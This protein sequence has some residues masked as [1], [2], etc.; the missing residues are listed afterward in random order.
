MKKAI[1]LIICILLASNLLFPQESNDKEER[2]I[3]KQEKKAQK[4]AKKAEKI[5]QG[6]FLISPLAAPGYTPELGGLF[7]IG[8]LTSFKTN[9]KDQLIQRSSFPFTFGY[10]TTGAIVV[11]GILNSYWLKDKLRIYVDFWYKDMP[12]NYWGIGYEN[13]DSTPK[14]DTTTAYQR[15]WWQINPRFLYQFTYNYFVGLNVDYNFTKGSDASAGVVSDSNYMIYNDRPFN[16]GLGLILCYDSRDIPVDTRQGLY[17]DLRATFYTTAFG[18]DN[19]Y[20]VYLVDY[21]Q[22]QTFMR[23]GMTLAWQIKARIGTGDIPYGEMSQLGTP[24]DLRGYTWGRYRD[25]SLFFF[26]AEYR[27][28]FLK[29]DGTLSKHCGVAWV[30][31]GTIF[32]TQTLRDS[33]NRWLPNFGVGYTFELQARMHLRLDFGIGREASGFYFNFQQAF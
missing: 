9:P 20:Q 25:E 12:D 15:Q 21:R 22:F 31:S 29:K 8:A 4:A 1:L 18:G 11:N 23:E 3:R 2:K 32:D 24:F 16:S 33:N 10:T 5:A 26:L 17:I 14:S 28:I 13:G 27:H 6:K 7:A 19:N 30:G